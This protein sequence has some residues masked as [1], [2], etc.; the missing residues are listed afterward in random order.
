[1][2]RRSSRRAQG[3]AISPLVLSR[4][5]NIDIFSWDAA[6]ESAAQNRAIAEVRRRNCEKAQSLE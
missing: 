1:M 5:C 6:R 2:L 4:C 3:V